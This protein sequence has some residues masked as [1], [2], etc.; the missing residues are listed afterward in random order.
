MAAM[1]YSENAVEWGAIY[2]TRTNETVRFLQPLAPFLEAVEGVEFH[3]A[4]S[5]K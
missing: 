1:R 4:L 3:L 2:S 5:F